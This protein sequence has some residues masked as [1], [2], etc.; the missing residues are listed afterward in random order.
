MLF[1]SNHVTLGLSIKSRDEIIKK[2]DIGNRMKP[3]FPDSERISSFSLFRIDKYTVTNKM[4]A[5]FDEDYY[6]NE[7]QADYPVVGINLRQAQAYAHW[8]GKDIPTED[9]W[10]YAARGTDFRYFPW[11]NDWDYESEINKEECEKNVIQVLQERMELEVQ[12][13]ILKE[14]VHLSVLIWL[15]MYGNGHKLLWENMMRTA[16]L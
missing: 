11:G 3:F 12:R 16:L 7:E 2:H 13:N 14:L 6:Y 4:Y 9:E 1:R 10:E 15:V 5:E 8:W